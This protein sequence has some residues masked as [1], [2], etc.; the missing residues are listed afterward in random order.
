M[1]L[2]IDENVSRSVAT[3][4]IEAGHEVE[5]VATALPSAR[6]DLV[7]AH[8]IV[9]DAVLVTFDADF[10]RMIFAERHASPKAVIFLRSPPPTPAETVG[11]ILRV[12]ASDAP[13]IDGHFVSVDATA[14][15]HPLPES[16]FN[17]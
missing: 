8:A 17:G 6:D 9:T 13:L 2:L 12:L 11:R 14:R 1:R 7:L 15:Y 10:G 3:A 4:L 16:N 5:R